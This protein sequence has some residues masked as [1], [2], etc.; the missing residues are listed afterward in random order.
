MTK[1][2]GIASA[3]CLAH[4]RIYSNQSLHLNR[5]NCKSSFYCFHP[6][7]YLLN[8]IT[9]LFLFFIKMALYI[10][11]IKYRKCPHFHQWPPVA[12][13]QS[14]KLPCVALCSLHCQ[15]F[16]KVWW[17]FRKNCICHPC[18]ESPEQILNKAIHLRLM[19]VSM[20][21]CC[22]GENW[23]CFKNRNTFSAALYSRDK[24]YYYYNTNSILT[25]N[26]HL[27]MIIH[28]H[29]NHVGI[30]CSLMPCR[31]KLCFH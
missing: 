23:G 4:T 28:F 16:R 14:L 1:I 27:M 3:G 19:L 25:S 15:V 12:H 11:I 21:C 29:N 26:Y 2:T 7:L 20:H 18:C 30:D 31:L 10:I 17:N 24:R 9:F 8:T 22:F 5:G 6:K 13:V